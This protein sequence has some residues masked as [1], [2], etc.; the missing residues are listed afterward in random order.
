[1]LDIVLLNGPPQSGKDTLGRLMNLHSGYKILK[2]AEPLRKAVP[3]MF[4]IDPY[5]YEK[6]IEDGELKEKPL[7]ALGGMSPREAQIWL[8]ET[9]M[10]PRLGKDIFGKILANTINNTRE[11]SRGLYVVTDCGFEAEANYLL[12]AFPGQ[13]RMIQMSRQGCNF[14]K[15]SRD[16]IDLPVDTFELFNSGLD[17]MELYNDVYHWLHT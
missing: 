8:S 15:D 6:W 12:N 2:C 9:V 3:A 1:M 10:K 16:Y 5:D 17:P 14:S 11:R 4:G 13:V 7:E